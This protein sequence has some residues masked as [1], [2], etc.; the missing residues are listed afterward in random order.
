MTAN[1]GRQVSELP[2]HRTRASGRPDVATAAADHGDD[3]MPYD[4]AGPT[5]RRRPADG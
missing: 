4:V 3:L 5:G 1:S 2:E